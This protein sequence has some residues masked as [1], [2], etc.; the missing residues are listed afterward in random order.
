MSGFT[1]LL[2]V[3]GATVLSAAVV[4]GP[5]ILADLLTDKGGDDV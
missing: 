5:L 1:V 4:L 2:L 3:L